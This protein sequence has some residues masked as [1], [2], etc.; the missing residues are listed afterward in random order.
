MPKHPYQQGKPLAT[1]ARHSIARYPVPALV[2]ATGDGFSSLSKSR[3]NSAP[4][5]IVWRF[6]TS[7]M[8]CHGGCAWEA[9]AP[10]GFLD[11]RSANPRTA[12][13]QNRLAAV[14]GSSNNQGAFPMTHRHTL[15]LNPSKI[16]ALA[17][18]RMAL[19]ALHADSSLAV[20]LNRY[21]EHMS[22][23]RALEAQRQGVS[24]DA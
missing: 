4:M 15:S 19:A 9:L 2:K 1:L 3:R 16:R 23:A 10:A 22:Q 17:H 7:A 14:R 11:S 5:T 12:A 21:N 18:R 20:R 8:L 13:T 24:H 6:F